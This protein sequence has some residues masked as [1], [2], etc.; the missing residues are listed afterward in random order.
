MRLLPVGLGLMRER[1]ARAALMPL[2]VTIG[3]I[4]R[5]G[6]S[7]NAL[8]GVAGTGTEKNFADRCVR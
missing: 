1:R 7:D 4:L 3:K 6:C 8:A 2:R 5:R